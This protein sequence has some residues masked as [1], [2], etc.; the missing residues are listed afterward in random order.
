MWLLRTGWSKP[1]SISKNIEVQHEPLT[2]I[3]N[4]PIPSVLNTSGFIDSEASVVAALSL[5]WL[6]HGF[7]LPL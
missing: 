5:N 6:V 1:V 4:N 2:N 3:K 7:N